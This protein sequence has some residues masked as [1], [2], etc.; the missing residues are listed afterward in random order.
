MTVNKNINI[1]VN[2]AKSLIPVQ[3]PQWQ[4][5]AITPVKFSGWDNRTFH[6]GDEMTIR[7]PSDESY[8][9]QILKEYQWLPKLSKEIT[10]EITQPLALGKPTE[11]YPWPWS[12]NKWIEGVSVSQEPVQDLVQL[13][14]DLGRFLQELHQIDSTG[15][16]VAGAHNF[17]RGGALSTYDAEMRPAIPLIEHSHHKSIAEQL[18]ND[19]LSSSWQDTPVWVHGDIAIGNL[20][21]KAGKLNAVIDFGQ[22]AIGDPACDLSIAWTLFSEES[23]TAFREAITLD[24]NTWIRALGWTLWKT[25]CWPVKGSNVKQIIHDVLHDYTTDYID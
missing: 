16:P 24:N 21:V 22:L 4:H 9:P 17:Y 12:I 19:A 13:A 15:G 25:V 8:A 2:L 1:D 5:L 6:L 18:W 14:N 3:F 10:L 20:L 7:L 23:R 11:A